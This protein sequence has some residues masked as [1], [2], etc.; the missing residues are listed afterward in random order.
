MIYLVSNN[1]T[2]LNDFKIIS[3][4]ESIKK[5]Q[6]LKEEISN[7][8][9]TTGLSCHTKTLLLLQL[10]NDD[11][12]IVY[13]IASYGG[14]IPNK[15]KEFMSSYNGIWI[16][17][18]AKFDLQF[19][20][21]Q[22]VILKR[23]YDTMLAEYILTIGLQEDGRDLQTLAWKYC[24]VA[25]DK[26][27]RGK[28]VK[29]GLTKDVILYAA[30]DIT[31]LSEI[32]R[33]QLALIKAKDLTNA[34][35]LDNAF[36]RVL[37]YIEYCGIKL[38]WDKWLKRTDRLVEKNNLRKEELESYLFTHGG[39]RYQGTIDMF[40][41]K[42][43]CLINWNS[44]KQVIPL[45]EAFGIN[46]ST[47]EKGE[48]KKSIEKKV[49]QFQIPNNELLQ[50]YFNYKESVKSTDTYGYNWKKLINESTKRIHCSYTQIMKTGRLSSNEPN[51]QNLPNDA[52]TRACFVVEPGNKMI[53]ADY[54]GQESIIMANF[55]RDEALL[56]F[57][58][59][60]LT[61]MHSFV[62]YLLYP[63]LQ[64]VPIENITNDVLEQIKTDH[65]D[66]R[67]I[68]KKAE[69]AIGYGGN[70]STIAKN[71]G[72]SE[73]QGKKVYDTYFEAFSG[74]KQYFDYVMAKTEQNHYIQ[75]NNITRRKYFIPD[76]DPFIDFVD[77]D[78]W[79]W[80]GQEY[81]KARA[82]IQRKSQNYPIQ[83]SA[84]D[85]SKLAGIIFFN[86]ILQ[87]G[88]FNKVKICNM[89]HDEYEVEC[90]ESMVD[91]VKDLLIAS[92]EKAGSYFCKIIPLKA[93]VD[94]GDHWIH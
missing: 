90:P 39:K 78:S 74:M 25:L 82:E 11:F 80:E 21:K 63:Q 53:C 1:T 38:D 52:E 73:A 4:E 33:K 89:V 35:N 62:A 23:V 61:D 43:E 54:S 48:I 58:R 46:C 27:I 7:D 57:Y 6:A 72:V 94:I 59:K 81:I 68:A 47:K 55:A 5:L 41:G 19:F 32:K 69:F 45:F 28:I 71:T 50:L 20:Y 49:L 17:Q 93:S 84:A 70:G 37:A 60:G 77:F 65:K 12:Q 76:T 83:G 26:T 8:T 79:T 9:E 24:K 87:R 75:Y 64:T 88:W 51:M 3:L 91:E 31:Y 66:L 18:N 42:P 10:G 2:F 15:L 34:L 16:L 22:G 36:V 86:N 14:V 92:M 40:T 44:A 56:T 30:K 29:V 13:D 67:N 85:C